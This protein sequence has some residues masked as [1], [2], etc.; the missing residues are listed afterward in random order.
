MGERKGVNVSHIE[1]RPLP[2]FPF[3]LPAESSDIIHSTPVTSDLAPHFKFV[4]DC[5]G[6]GSNKQILEN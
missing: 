5:P 6:K 1:N 3:E 4:H 2:E